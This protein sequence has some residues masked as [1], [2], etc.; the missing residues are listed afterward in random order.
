MVDVRSDFGQLLSGSIQGI[1]DLLD[2]RVIRA[3]V[4]EEYMH[5]SV[6]WSHCMCQLACESGQ[7]MVS[8]LGVV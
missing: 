5:C 4:T 8:L 2:L 7:V 6:D 1:D 3:M